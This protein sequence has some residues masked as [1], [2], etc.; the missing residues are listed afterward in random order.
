MMM[1]ERERERERE[2]NEIVKNETHIRG[3][4]AP[5]TLDEKDPKCRPVPSGHTSERNPKPTETDLYFKSPTTAAQWQNT[6]MRTYFEE[7]A[8]ISAVFP[9]QV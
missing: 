5:H 1:G 2:N 4:R 6:V 8:A 7:E 9:P 3:S